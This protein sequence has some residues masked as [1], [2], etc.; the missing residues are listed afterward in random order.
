MMNVA[1]N[2]ILYTS[3]KKKKKQHS[4]TEISLKIKYKNNLPPQYDTV[5]YPK[6]QIAQN[7]FYLYQNNFIQTYN[8][9]H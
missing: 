2:D 8:R 5:F 9:N 1:Q 4:Y 6:V 7:V 3:K